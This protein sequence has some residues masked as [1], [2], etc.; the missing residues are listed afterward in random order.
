MLPTIHPALFTLDRQFVSGFQAHSPQQVDEA[1][2]VTVNGQDIESVSLPKLAFLQRLNDQ[3][4]AWRDEHLSHVHVVEQR[5]EICPI[6]RP[7]RFVTPV[8]TIPAV[9]TR[10]EAIMMGDAS[11]NHPRPALG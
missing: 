8:W 4:R 11:P 6:Q 3:L 5:P 10:T 9:I 1:L 2:T 7:R